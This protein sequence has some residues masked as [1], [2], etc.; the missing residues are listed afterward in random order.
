MP[1]ARHALA[2]PLLPWPVQNRWHDG[3]W[4]RVQ[5]TVPLPVPAA[6]GRW[7]IDRRLYA[8]GNDFTSAS[9]ELDPHYQGNSY[10]KKIWQGFMGS[11]L[12]D[13]QAVRLFLLGHR[14]RIAGVAAWLMPVDDDQTPTLAWAPEVPMHPRHLPKRQ[15]AYGHIGQAMVYLKPA[16]RGQG[17][18]RWLLQALLDQ[19]HP[20]ALRTRALGAIPVLAASDA[21]VC[22]LQSLQAPPLVSRLETHAPGAALR[23]ELWS[24]HERMQL[25][26]HEHTP[27]AAWNQ[28]P[29][30]MPAPGTRRAAG[31]R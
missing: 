23:R 6:V 12:S 5:L 11:Q 13:A 10:L 27:A 29:T 31:P 30:A 9:A 21:T 28:A 25:H 4:E 1:A 24:W 2:D 16:F 15:L 22:L 26:T 3:D 19:A 20:L 14:G 8:R 7:L 17:R 18:A